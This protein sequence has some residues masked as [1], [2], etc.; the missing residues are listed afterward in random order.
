MTTT[1][2]E[3]KGL[4]EILKLKNKGFEIPDFFMLTFVGAA[5][6]SARGMLTYKLAGT[7]LANFHL[8]LVD[9][10]DFLS[11][12]NNVNNKKIAKKTVTKKASK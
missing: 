1:G 6:S 5:V 7:I 2:F 4:N 9:P 11:Q 12:I 3:V 10:R 8:P